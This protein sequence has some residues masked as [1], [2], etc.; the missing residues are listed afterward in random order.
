MKRSIVCSCILLLVVFTV[1]AA[2]KTWTGGAGDSLFSSDANWSPSGAPASG[3]ALIFSNSVAESVISVVNDLADF[4]FSGISA[5]GTNTVTF[6]NTGVGFT[7][8]GD[9]TVSGSGALNLNVPVTL[10]SD[11]TF[12]LSGAHI[13]TY[14]SISG[15]GSITIEGGNI[16][17]AH[18]EVGL[19]GGVISNNG[20]VYVYDTG[21]TAPL[22]LNQRRVD[23]VS[24]VLMKFETSGNYNL[25]ITINNADGTI[26]AISSAYGTT[27]TNTGAIIIGPNAYTRWNP[28]GPMTYAGGITIQE[29]ARST[30]SIVLN[31]PNIISGVPFNW[32]NNIYQDN[33]YLR[34]AVAGNKY[35]QLRVY[36]D[37][38]YTDV[39]GALDPDATVH[40][41]VSYRNGGNLDINGNDQ[42]INR[43]I[44][45]YR[46]TTKPDAFK[47]TSSSGPATLTCQGTADSTFYGSFNGELS[48]VWE[49]V[50]DDHTL[51]VTAKVSETSGVLEVKAGTLALAGGAA[52]PNVTAL[53]ASGTGILHV[54]GADIPSVPLTVSDTAQL[55]LPSGI[56]LICENAQVDGAA[57]TAG[58]YTVSNTVGGRT[59]ITGDGTL[60]VLTVPLSSTVRTWTGAGEDTNFSN[61]NNWDAAP[62]FDGSETF[63]F[64]S[65]GTSAILDDE[66]ALGAI[67][68]D[69]GAPF[70]IT[71]ADEN[72]GIQ[73]GLGDVSVLTP[74]GGTE[75]THTIAAPLALSGAHDFQIGSNQ[76]LAISGPITGG[77]PTESL[78]KSDVGT[79]HLT[80]TNTFESPV[81]ISDGCL[82][83]NNGTAFGNPT[84]T[85]TVERNTTTDNSWNQRGAIYF[86]D[87]VITNNRP[88]IIASNV[89]YIGQIYPPSAT[90]VLNGK[91]TFLGNGRIDNKGDL[92][93][94]GGFDSVNARPWMQTAGGKSMRFEEEPLNFGTFGIATDNTGTFN[95]CAT[96]NTWTKLELLNSTFLCGVD[97][98]MPTNSYVTF[99][100]SY[101]QTG[102]LDLNG[103]DQQ[104]RLVNNASASNSQTNMV[105]KSA[106][107]AT[108]TLKGDTSARSFVGYFTGKVSLRY[109]NS[110]TMTLKGLTSASDTDGDLIIESGAV[111]FANGSTWTG[112]TN[113]T[114]TA[115]TLSV[116]GGNGDTFG[117][118]NASINNTRLHLTSASTVNLADGVEEYVNAGTL[119][120]ERLTVGTYGSTTSSAQFKSALFTGTGILHVMR[121]DAAGTLIMVR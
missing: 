12:M 73:L 84:N 45:D 49:P 32:P 104:I 89:H 99:G 10:D 55:S 86:T 93:F 4:T 111:A 24:Y 107:Q 51:T 85:I 75:V 109:R 83:A 120:G 82:M 68:F 77:V 52:F 103:F 20:K 21:F 62:L 67:R 76:T 22:T 50:S 29:P 92:L 25:P 2:D 70:S 117:G 5:T 71:A 98:A 91:F 116:E 46:D 56:D 48:L 39:P 64:A 90:L 9:I 60:T 57:L 6:G 65:A 96:N 61:T 94:R 118:S 58:V 15:S 13:Y 36:T 38:I 79:L 100:A 95:V 113:I 8:T 53:T 43:P 88:L 63:L 101:T 78:I 105:I 23:N 112:S 7:L 66:F 74:A 30:M 19:T 18:D 41:G 119:D 44:I 69:R 110:G 106:E 97:S 54:D 80:G 26:Y 14:G 59:F 121:S 37:T 31:G 33:T 35:K 16:F 114:V 40:F 47:I 108:L 17:Y 42:T 87:M 72:S 3:D 102:Y 34:L 27:V 1:S 115:G 11:V 28:G 81:V